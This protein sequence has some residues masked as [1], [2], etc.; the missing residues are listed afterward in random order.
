[1]NSRRATVNRVPL[2][3]SFQKSRFAPSAQPRKWWPDNHSGG[4]AISGSR[5]G[6]CW[7]TLAHN[8]VGM[9]IRKKRYDGRMSLGHKVTTLSSLM[10]L[11]AFAVSAL[12]SLIAIQAQTTELDRFVGVDLWKD[13]LA[14][15]E[16]RR[17]D[18]VIGKVPKGYLT[19]PAA[20]HVWK[21]TRDGKTRY[22]VLLGEPLVMIPGGSAACVRLFDATANKIN[23]WSFQAGWRT[24]LYD[25]SIEYSNDLVSDL[26]VLRTSPVVGGR[27]VAKEYLALNN[28]RLRFIRM[29]SDKGA[30]AQN[31]YVF[32][33]YEIGIV[34]AAHT[35]EQWS[36]LLESKDKVDVLSALV[37]LGGK[38]EH[39]L[40]FPDESKYI[41]LFR[42]L[43]GNARIRELIERLSN[44]DNEWIKQAALLAARGPRERSTQ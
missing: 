32:P 33:N 9:V 31:E 2:R 3:C 15:N 41:V 34:P 26:I 43:T 23:S 14:E 8:V 30:L 39:P 7:A 19:E 42:E 28:D 4:I 35:V 22:I 40:P 20:W 11:F 38:H 12:G 25:A 6:R 44:S 13:R 27:D 10:V 18:E 1:M 37:F 16:Q 21:T 5:Q 29:E 24:V 36:A 17:L